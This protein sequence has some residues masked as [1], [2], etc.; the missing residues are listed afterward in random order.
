MIESLLSSGF[1]TL[2][3]YWVKATI[4]IC[5]FVDYSV[6]KKHPHTFNTCSWVP[7]PRYLTDISGGYNLGGASFPHHTPRPSH[8]TVLCFPLMVP[9]DLRLIIQQLPTEL[10]REETLNLASGTL[11]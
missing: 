11:H 8:P 7:I 2:E 5:T 1:N 3:Y 9:S 4:G 6:A 10:K